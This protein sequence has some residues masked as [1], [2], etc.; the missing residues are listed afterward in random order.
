MKRPRHPY[1][2]HFNPLPSIEEIAE[3]YRYDRRT[4]RFYWVYSGAGGGRGV[5]CVER[6]GGNG[7]RTLN[8]PRTRKRGNGSFAAH[9]IAWKV[10]T[11]SDPVGVVDHRNGMRD[12]N[13]PEN[14][15]DVHPMVNAQNNH[16]DLWE[17]ETGR[18]KLATK[19]RRQRA[20]MSRAA[21]AGDIS[22]AMLSFP[23]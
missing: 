8:F 20:R 14:L 10:I 9:R 11:G 3:R 12:D 4:G 6:Q 19:E 23:S 5:A 13:R 18:R 17:Q 16:G 7:Y 1:P 22:R 21:R 15:R 2:A